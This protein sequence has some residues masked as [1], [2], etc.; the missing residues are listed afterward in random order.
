MSEMKTFLDVLLADEIVRDFEKH[1]E[2]VKELV[3][4]RDKDGDFA[5]KAGGLGAFPLLAHLGEGEITLIHHLTPGTLNVITKKREATRVVRGIVDG[6]IPMEV[7]GLD[8]EVCKKGKA[9][10]RDKILRLTEHPEEAT[11]LSL[12][13]T[14]LAIRSFTFCHGEFLDFFTEHNEPVPG[15]LLLRECARVCLA[16]RESVAD[17]EEAVE[18]RRGVFEWLANVTRGNAP[19]F[20]FRPITSKATKAWHRALQMRVLNG[21]TGQEGAKA[22]GMRAQEES[23]TTER[24][25]LTREPEVRMVTPPPREK[26]AFEKLLKFNQKIFLF[27]TFDGVD[28][29]KEPA[30]CLV[31]ILS[32]KSSAEALRLLRCLAVH[33]K[34]GFWVQPDML[35]QLRRGQVVGESVSV[36]EGLT[37][38]GTPSCPPE[39]TLRSLD[40]QSRSFTVAGVRVVSDGGELLPRHGK[41]GRAGFVIPSTIDELLHHLKNYKFLITLICGESSLL[42]EQYRHA[43]EIIEEY[44]VDLAS[45]ARSDRDLPG[46]MLWFIHL[47]TQAYLRSCSEAAS[48]GDI[49][50]QTLNWGEVLQA[51]GQGTS[52]LIFSSGPA[53]FKRGS[54]LLTEE[55]EK[56]KLKDRGHPSGGGATNRY[57]K[58]RYKGSKG[59]RL[60]DTG[61]RKQIPAPTN[62]NGR[63][64]CL[65][66]HILG[67]CAKGARCN[68]RSSHGWLQPEAHGRLL[69][70]ARD[71]EAPVVPGGFPPQNQGGNQVKGR[72]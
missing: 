67:K 60:Y 27:L 44:S 33:K 21:V 9:F 3:A 42:G 4:P 64:I 32:C 6:G 5:T 8:E 23:E 49:R 34:R 12:T 48:A 15:E 20:P 62:D 68:M 24:Q 28:V 61:Q 26:N 72:G 11:S 29:E 57:Q 53:F 10:K 50:G 63:P 35:N 43:I 65:D 66:F 7:K 22:K 14:A 2:A 30:Q 19:E 40:D 52:N 71:C 39:L 47:K 69:K 59:R 51:T 1:A 55:Q 36:P 54:A 25:S 31:E 56:G 46:K 18:K 13:S 17:K 41:N 45:M 58:E 38:F 16:D 70:W 37:P